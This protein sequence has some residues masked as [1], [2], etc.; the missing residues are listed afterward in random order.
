[1]LDR[2][3]AKILEEL[4]NICADGSYKVVEI[5]DICDAMPK[6]MSLDSESL[7]QSINHLVERNYVSLKYFDDEVF[8]I[9]VLPKGRLFKEKN[10]ELKI[11]KDKKFE[12]AWVSMICG[13]VGAFIGSAISTILVLLII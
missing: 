10:D 4:N 6:K 1:M 13:A 5:K 3:T 2:R 8:C 11:A 12:I 7:E 9:S